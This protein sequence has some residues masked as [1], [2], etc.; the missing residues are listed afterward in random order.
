MPFKMPFKNK[1]IGKRKRKN[2]PAKGT[3]TAEKTNKK[4]TGSNLEKEL[5]LL[6]TVFF[7]KGDKLLTIEYPVQRLT[8]NKKAGNARNLALPDQELTLD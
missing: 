2:G 7:F 6:L 8:F 3:K 5:S 1:T 4:I